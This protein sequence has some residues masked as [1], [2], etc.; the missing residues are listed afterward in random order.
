[1]RTDPISEFRRRRFNAMA[2][3]FFWVVLIIVLLWGSPLCIASQYHGHP[4]W[5]Y[6]VRDYASCAPAL[7]RHYLSRGHDCRFRHIEGVNEIVCYIDGVVYTITGDAWV[8][9][10]GYEADTLIRLI[11]DVLP[12]DLAMVYV[13]RGE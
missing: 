11:D 3:G 10:P 4:K 2:A 13:R 7:E 1:M 9:Y 6:P 5:D 12:F 8:S